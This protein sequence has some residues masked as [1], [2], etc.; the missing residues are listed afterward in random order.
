VKAASLI[1]G[2]L[3]IATL[4]FSIVAHMAGWHAL[5]LPKEYLLA[6]LGVGA[7]LIAASAGLLEGKLFKVSKSGIEIQDME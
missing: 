7:F 2:V 3:L 6:C 4:P 1:C 5:D